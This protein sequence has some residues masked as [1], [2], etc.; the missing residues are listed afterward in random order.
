[1]QSGIRPLVI[2]VAIL[3]AAL[4]S[5]RPVQTDVVTLSTGGQV[6]GTLA[7]G[8]SP[9][10]NRPVAIVTGTGGVVTFN[11]DAVLKVQRG[12]LPASKTAGASNR[13]HLSPE[14]QAWMP[15]I[16][17]LVS[18]LFDD[19]ANQRRRARTKL[20]QINDRA[21]IPALTQ[22]LARS[23]SAEA[24]QLYISIVHTLPG[25]TPA[26]YLVA[27]SLFDPSPQ[28][29]DEA[30][31]SIGP[32]K[33]EAARVMY[34]EALKTRDSD[35]ASR[36]AKGIAAIGD[37]QKDAVPY[38]IDTLI[39]QNP[40]PEVWSY[41]HDCKCSPSRA[42]LMMYGHRRAYGYASEPLV[43]TYR[44]PFSG[45]NSA[46]LDALVKVSDQK[47]PGYGAS[48][49][50]WRRWWAT[51]KAHRELHPDR[52]IAKPKSSDSL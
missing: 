39:Y 47:Y 30:R 9:K 28:V 15:K 26:Y 44:T 24:R 36:A 29:R 7:P 33:A 2:C 48:A 40:R 1:M 41:H 5:A 19:D 10:G 11:R 27:L 16:A 38:L 31:S 25:Q 8:S 49:D 46:V 23:S 34:I 35:V 51:D 32:D 37:P 43:S 17:S 50:S 45:V 20:S 6:H 14:E 52:V 12:G 4:F 22:Y 18:R 21:A 13:V 42:M 3:W